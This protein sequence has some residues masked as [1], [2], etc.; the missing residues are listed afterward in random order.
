MIN[1]NDFT[2]GILVN[3]VV[4]IIVFLILR[5]VICWYW[6]INRNVALFTE[7]RDLLA[8][9]GNSQGGVVPIAQQS[10]SSPDTESEIFEC[11]KPIERDANS[12]RVNQKVD[13]TDKFS[14]KFAG[15]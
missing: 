10:P 8:A 13:Y 14:D 2:S 15:K 3:I 9:K 6:K 4:A 11:D 12:I 1:G 7:I 5:E